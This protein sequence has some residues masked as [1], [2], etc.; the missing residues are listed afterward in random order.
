MRC[1]FHSEKRG[2]DWNQSPLFAGQ[3]TTEPSWP[4]LMQATCMHRR[5]VYRDGNSG[6]HYQREDEDVAPP[7]VPKLDGEE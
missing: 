4:V 2:P 3:V 1:E 7:G 5:C 6:R